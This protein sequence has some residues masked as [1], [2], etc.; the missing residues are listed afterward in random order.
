MAAD[1]HVLS[2]SY[3]DFWVLGFR[4]LVLNP[5]LVLIGRSCCLDCHSSNILHQHFRFIR[6]L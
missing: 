1:S 6:Y 2:H 3:L 5:G 4:F